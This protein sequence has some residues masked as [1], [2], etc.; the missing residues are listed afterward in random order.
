MT[1]ISPELRQRVAEAARH[2]CGYCQTQEVIIGMPLEIEHI[3]P[4]AAGGSSDEMN[5]WLACPRCNRYKGD[6]THA[7]DDETGE[8]VPLFDPR[9]FCLGPRWSLYRRLDCCWPCHYSGL[10]GE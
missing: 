4:E 2:Q 5:L 1:Y 6:Q 10:A 3:V 8:I 9:S 7:K